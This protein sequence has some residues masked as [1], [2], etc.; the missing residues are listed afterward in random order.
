MNTEHLTNILKIGV[1]LSAEK[2]LDRLLGQVL[3]TVMQLTRCDAGTL[4]LKEG[5][6]LHFELM[7]TDSM[8]FSAG[9]EGKSIDLPPVRMERSNVCALSL[10]EDRTICVEDVYQ[11]TE[12][13]F[14]GPKHYDALTGYHTRSMLVVPMKNRRGEQIGVLQLINALDEAGNVISFSEDHILAVESVAS[15]A[16]T[17]IQNARYIHEINELFDSVVR[18][19]ASAVDERTPYNANH[20]RNMA[21]YGD[22][23]LTWLNENA[24]REHP[25]YAFGS[26]RRREFLMSVQFHDIGKLIT[27]LGIMNK[28][29]RLTPIRKERVFSRFENF[30]LKAEILLLKGKISV[31]EQEDIDRLLQEAAETVCTASAA[32]Y[33]SDELLEKL[34][35]LGRDRFPSEEGPEPYLTEE[36]LSLLTIRKGTL[37]PEERH[38]MEEHVVI[39]DRLLSN[40]RFNDELKHVRAW[41]S[42]HHEMLDGSG[43]PDHRT[44]ESIPTEVRI[45]TI[46]DIFDALYANDRPYKKAMPLEKALGILRAMAHSE[47]KLDPVLTDLFIES[48]CWETPA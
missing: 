35:A 1:A 6:L 2:D 39:T 32:G 33:L 16:A 4:Y 13:D 48:R 11:S 24:A 23:F 38:I 46:L 19:M 20:T 9:E 7:R 12:A 10:L 40:I 3:H 25:E 47:G 31:R 44:A 45:L 34:Q 14:T 22:R 30:R 17:A 26:A 29:E 21:E 41:A 42:A 8:N 43:Y 28:S 36:E 15:Q 37:S 18:V 5:D 27:P